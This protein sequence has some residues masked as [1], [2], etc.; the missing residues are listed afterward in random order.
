VSSLLTLLILLLSSP[1]LYGQSSQSE[2]ST[3]KSANDLELVTLDG[4]L[5]ASMG[6]YVLTEDNLTT[7]E[8]SGNGKKLKPALGHQVKLT[9]KNGTR[10][11]DTTPVGMA[12]SVTVLAVF[13]VKSVEH[14]GDKCGK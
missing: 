7:H 3:K 8:L 1:A 11:V 13:D 9:G 2:Q 6:H 10:T 5:S 14:V 12:S 4:S